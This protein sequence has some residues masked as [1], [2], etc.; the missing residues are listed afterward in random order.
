M[1]KDISKGVNAALSRYLVFTRE[2]WAQRRNSTPLTISEERLSALRSLND[3]ISLQEVE[4]AY[5]PLS[6]L[7]QLYVAAAQ[8]LHAATSTFLDS[9][10]AQVPYVIGIGG[11]VAVGKS[12][13]ARLLQALL[14]D[15]PSHPNVELVT[16]D[17]FLFS[18]A[19]L[20]K[21]GLLNRK[22]FP[23]SYDVP[24]LVRFLAAVKA[25]E[26]EVAVPV[27]SHHI[28][29]IV[30]GQAQIV[31]QP[32]ILIVEGLNV[33]QD[34]TSRSRKQPRLYVS[35]FFD[36]T[37]YVDSE[38]EDIEYWFVER[39][40]TL[41]ETAFRDPT[42]FFTRFANLSQDEAIQLAHYVW[43]EINGLNLRENILPTRERAHLI[44]RK[45]RDHSIQ[46]VKLRKL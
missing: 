42:S 19:V 34:T 26:P 12:T 8:N 20:E 16:T 38:E 18:N 46:E 14:S 40:L 44:L 31:R 9:A 5:L 13:T 1:Q 17:A 35:D 25:G 6:R 30:P 7:L 11:S 15:W 32:D 33:L 36:F 27:Y 39:F 29:D 45:N 28:Y 2:E 43:Q 23:E 41:W 21:R 3:R 37:I 22:G 4:H 10:S 24:R